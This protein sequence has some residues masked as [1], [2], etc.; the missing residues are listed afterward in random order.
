VYFNGIKLRRLKL[1]TH[2]QFFDE[3]TSGTYL[4]YLEWWK[5]CF[6]ILDDLLQFRI[7][8]Q[9]LKKKAAENR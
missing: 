1:L 2:R 3:Q 7:L 5:P 6:E 8:A 4:K 9:E